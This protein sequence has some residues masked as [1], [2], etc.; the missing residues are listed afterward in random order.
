MNCIDTFIGKAFNAKRLYLVQIVKGQGAVGVGKDS[1]FSKAFFLVSF[2]SSSSLDKVRIYTA[3]QIHHTY[4][5][6]CAAAFW[7]SIT[8]SDFPIATERLFSS[9]SVGS[10]SITVGLSSIPVE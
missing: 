10:S 2:L 9:I 3:S 4:L 5:F 6:Y 1:E 8:T 7:V